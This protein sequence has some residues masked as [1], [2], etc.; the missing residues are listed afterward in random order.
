[1]FRS[2]LSVVLLL[3][4][5]VAQ[6]VSSSGERLL[7]VLEDVAEKAAHSTFLGDLEGRLAIIQTRGVRM[8][9]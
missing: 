1:M 2:L 9:S 6:A 8:G 3:L 5:A 7:V 4:A